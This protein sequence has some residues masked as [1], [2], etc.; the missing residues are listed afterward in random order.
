MKHFLTSTAA[1][2]VLTTASY[3]QD[4]GA[5]VDYTFDQAT[6][7]FASDLLGARIYATEADVGDM[8]EPGAE[9]E[10]DDLGEINDMILSRD[11]EVRAVILGIGGFLG[12]GERDVAVDMRSIS[13]VRDGPDAT[14]YFLVVN[15]N[16]ETVE[17]ATEFSRNMAEQVNT[18]TGMA[19]MQ[20]DGTAVEPAAGTVVTD[21][22][23]PAMDTEA[24]P[25]A[26]V[27]VPAEGETEMAEP[28][29][30]APDGNSELVVTDETAMT[31]TPAMRPDRAMLS[32]PIIARD[33]YAQVGA[34]EL[35]AD[36]LE[37]ARVYGANDEDVGEIDTLILGADGQS[38]EEVVID[39]GGFL[40]IGEKPVAVTLDELAIMRSADGTDLRVYIDATEEQLENQ[41]DYVR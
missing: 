21:T 40:G 1:A 27:V 25:D 30:V 11:G 26:V 10:W 29:A 31:D 3:A 38:V 22:T 20:Q 19:T 14:D 16:R 24:D 13:I 9:T 23:A 2:L 18:T 28:T 15:A 34:G 8:V 5:F 12:I 17:G 37:G 39:V 4:G 35:T 36:D 6:D 7:L 32:A 33:D 41:P